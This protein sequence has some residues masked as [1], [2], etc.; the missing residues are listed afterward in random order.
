MLLHPSPS[1]KAL[2]FFFSKFG[3]TFALCLT[4]SEVSCGEQTI[5]KRLPGGAHHVS[6]QSLFLHHKSTSS[7]TLGIVAI[8]LLCRG[9]CPQT[10]TRTYLWLNLKA[11]GHGAPRAPHASVPAAR[12]S[13]GRPAALARWGP[14]H[15]ASRLQSLRRLRVP[16][17]NVAPAHLL[18]INQRDQQVR[19]C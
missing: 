7:H 18:F 5:S 17:L 16:A 11:K 15:T 14:R 1:D 10:I 2:S 13:R 12:A 4:F 6:A 19:R 3:V 8:T 9:I